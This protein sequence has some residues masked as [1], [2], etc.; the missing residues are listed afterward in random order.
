MKTMLWQETEVE[1]DFLYINDLD[2]DEDFYQAS[3]D[4]L[5]AHDEIEVISTDIGERPAGAEYV[6]A[7]DTHKWNVATFDWLGSLRQRFLDLARERGYDYAFLVDSDLL[8]DPRTLQSLLDTEKDIVAGVFW[9]EWNTGAPMMPQVWLK[10]PYGLSGR[11][12]DEHK[13]LQALSNG[14]LVQVYGLGACTLFKT[15]V[16]DKVAYYP[17]LQG[18]P[19]GGMWQGEDRSFCIRA[20]RAHVEMWA[21]S[22]PNIWHIYRPEYEEKIDYMTDMLKSLNKEERPQYGDYIS[23][24]L[25]STSNKKLVNQDGEPFFFPPLG[26]VEHVRGILGKVPLMPEIEAEVFNLKPRGEALVKVSY[27]VW[28]DI[29]EYRGSEKIIRLSLKDVKHADS[30]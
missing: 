26:H 13:F 14:D 30:R 16:L 27:P 22:W 23:L 8:L 21:D 7:S 9:T 18:L 15:S 20:E 5:F 28:H 29:T 2:P 17:L 24:T 10:H 25:E 11:G 19:E 12:W 6:A 4:V 3:S 1:V